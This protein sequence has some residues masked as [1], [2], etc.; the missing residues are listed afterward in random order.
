MVICSIDFGICIK[1]TNFF[2]VFHLICTTFAVEMLYLTSY[3]PITSPTLI[4]FVVLLIIL[5]VMLTII[6]IQSLFWT[7][8]GWFFEDVWHWLKRRR[9]GKK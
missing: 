6:S 8:I 2:F 7:R 3:F 5:I 9:T 1:K 4:F